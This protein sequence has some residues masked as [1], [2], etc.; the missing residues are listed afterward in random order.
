MGFLSGN[1]RI[2]NADPELLFFYSLELETLLPGFS[3]TFDFVEIRVN[4][5]AAISL[6]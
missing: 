1:P 2:F 6:R 5:S 3:F 4:L